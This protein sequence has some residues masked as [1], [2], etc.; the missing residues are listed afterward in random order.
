[1]RKLRIYL[2]NCCYYRPFDDLS[3]TRIALESKAILNIMR[4][5]KKS[6]HILLGSGALDIEISRATDIVKRTNACGLYDLHTE[7]IELNENI[8]LRAKEFE[9][10]GI[11]SFDALHIAYAE[12]AKADVFLTT[13]DDLLKAAKRIKPNIVAENPVTWLMEVLRNE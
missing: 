3:Q 6:W 9:K 7:Y 12:F 11:T 13:D 4:M 5:C 1:M 10:S 8:Y 2:D